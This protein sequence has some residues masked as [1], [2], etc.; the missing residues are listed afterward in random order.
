MNSKGN[1]IL[2]W[3]ISLSAT[4]GLAQF[5][6]PSMDI[7]LKSG[8]AVLPDVN[9]DFNN[10]YTYTAPLLYSEINWNISQ[11]FAAGAFLTTGVYSTSNFAFTGESGSSNTSYGSSHLAYG[12]KLRASSGRQLR[13]RPFAEFSYGK[14]DMYVEKNVYRISNST[15]FFGISFGLMV[16]LGSKLYL[17]LPQATIR[18]RK[19]GFFFEPAGNYLFSS[20][21]PFIELSGGLSYNIGKKK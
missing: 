9:D 8:V 10:H 17:V 11:H 6:L 2:I 16:R 7:Q 12:I 14:L 5:H 13:F 20:Y 19:N 18:M 4:T 21:T 15:T 1:F 3:I